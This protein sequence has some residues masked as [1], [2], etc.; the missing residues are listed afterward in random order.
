MS[1]CSTDTVTGESYSHKAE[2]QVRV[3]FHAKGELI[4][5][6]FLKYIYFGNEL[7]SIKRKRNRKKKQSNLLN[8]V[9]P[10]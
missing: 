2:L 6:F 7:H 3:L 4:L 9:T 8:L 5:G 10:F 1:R